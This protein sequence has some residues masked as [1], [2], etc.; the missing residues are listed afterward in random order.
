MALVRNKFITG[1]T[2]YFINHTPYQLD[3]G[4]EVIDNISSMYSINIEEK[5]TPL[6]VNQG[7][8]S[9]NTFT[10]TFRIKNLTENTDLEVELSSKENFITFDNNI[11]IVLPM[12]TRAVEIFLDKSKVNSLDG[13]KLISEQVT[14]S[15]RNIVTGQTT[16]RTASTS[17]LDKIVLP[18]E[19]TIE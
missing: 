5:N 4:Q 14:V 16:T 11:F 2:D 18:D 8:G 17:M 19:V 9:E 13:A 15:I 12:E 10:V 3:A 1:I 6:L 7:F